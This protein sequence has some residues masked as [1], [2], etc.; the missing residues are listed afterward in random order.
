M[1]G[2]GLSYPL[3]R[4]RLLD[5]RAQRQRQAFV[6][7]FCEVRIL[8]VPLLRGRRRIWARPL[9]RQLALQLARLHHGGRHRGWPLG[10]CA[11]GSSHCDLG[12]AGRLVL[13]AHD[14][15]GQHPGARYE[16]FEM[17]NSTSLNDVIVF[18]RRLPPP[19]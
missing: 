3:Q 15:A 11:L 14:A 12:A 16:P 8:A 10:D 9:A 7:C 18:V 13:I 6:L 4:L 17:G 1:A 19:V 5:P 2:F